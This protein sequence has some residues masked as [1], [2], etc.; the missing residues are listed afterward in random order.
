MPLASNASSKSLKMMYFLR[1]ER[2]NS[3]KVAYRK[4]SKKLGQKDI[5]KIK[6]REKIQ[7]VKKKD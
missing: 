5:R 1:K 3:V 4:K 6:K 2:K 7:R